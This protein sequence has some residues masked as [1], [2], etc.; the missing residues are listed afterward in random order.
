MRDDLVLVLDCGSTN[1][2]AVA[3]KESGEL[4]AAASR[5]NRSV[6][7]P[8]GRS[9]WLIWDLEE[10]WKKIAETVREVSRRVGADAIKAVTFTTW[11]ADGAP[12]SRDGKPTYPPISWQCQRTKGIAE[13]IPEKISAWEIYKITGYQVISFNTLL[14]M[15]W[16]RQNVPDA[17]DR[18]HAWLM[19]PGLLAF[20]L[21]GEFH[22]EPTS[23]STTMAMDLLRRDWSRRLLRLADL[24]AS[25]F[26]KWCE[27]GDIVGEVT[28]DAG[29]ICN[30]RPGRSGCRLWT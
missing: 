26:P 9:E 23:A 28:G 16:L 29:R 25:F 17:L 4:V 20:R 10:I 30:L 2:R 18:A 3:V 21:T 14:K 15:M 24:D 6:G 12:V 11:G 27:P 7:Q 5:A 19:M 13:E 22:I 8:G 1:I